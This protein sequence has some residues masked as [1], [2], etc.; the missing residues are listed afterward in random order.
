MEN[1]TVTQPPEALLSLGIEGVIVFGVLSLAALIVTY[2][3]ANKRAKAAPIILLG[4]FLMAGCGTTPKAY[5]EADRATY[6]AVAPSY[7]EYVEAD[8]T[9][10]DMSKALRLATL[11]SWFM[12]LRAAEEAE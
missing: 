2:L 4:A 9:L 11:D 1:E 3:I 5:I 8:E 12:R 6:D 7:R 10:T